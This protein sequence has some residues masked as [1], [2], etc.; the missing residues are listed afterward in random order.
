MSINKYISIEIDEY[1]KMRDDHKT[2]RLD[3]TLLQ[4]QLV[5]IKARFLALLET[6]RRRALWPEEADKILKEM[7]L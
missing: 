3:Y 6:A 2:L 4:G 1:N 5:L 7:G